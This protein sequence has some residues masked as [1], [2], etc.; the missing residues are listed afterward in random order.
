M[1]FSCPFDWMEVVT[2]TTFKQEFAMTLQMMT[3]FRKWKTKVG[4][5]GTFVLFKF[6]VKSFHVIQE[7][8]L[9]NGNVWTVLGT[10]DIPKIMSNCKP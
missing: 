6:F 7:H 1:S 4:T 8:S 3:N 10:T 5:M 9:I 2:M